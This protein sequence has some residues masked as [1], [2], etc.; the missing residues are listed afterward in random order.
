MA[1]NQERFMR[2]IYVAAFTLVSVSVL[3]GAENASPNLKAADALADWARGMKAFKSDSIT[4]TNRFRWIYAIPE[5]RRG[6]SI[7]RNHCAVLKSMASGTN[8]NV[9][10][11][12]NHLL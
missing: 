7:K 6:L 4:T 10:S 12:Q 3:V 2:S 5:R 11:T 1:K 9:P 8:G